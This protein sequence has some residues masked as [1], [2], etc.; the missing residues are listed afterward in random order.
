MDSLFP[1]HLEKLYYLHLEDF[2]DYEYIYHSWNNHWHLPNT[3]HC[4]LLRL[5]LRLILSW[6]STIL[7][8]N[9]LC[10]LSSYNIVENETHRVLECFPYNITRI[11][12]FFKIYST[13][14]SQVYLPIRSMGRYLP[15]S[16]R[17][18]HTWLPYK[19]NIFVTILMQQTLSPVSLLASRTWQST[20]FHFTSHSTHFNWKISYPEVGN[21]WPI[22]PSCS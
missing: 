19:I 16:R 7:R 21:R 20:S 13:K 12:N 6:W 4:S 10:H 18:H 14:Q 22:D 3:N 8:Y 5:N 15:L 1:P 9:K 17:I 11:I 2:L